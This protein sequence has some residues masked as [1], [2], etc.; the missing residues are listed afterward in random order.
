MAKALVYPSFYEG[1]GFQPLEAMA[2]GTPVVASHLT[3]LPEI[4]GDAGLLV[5]PY[6]SSSLASALDQVLEN[7]KLREI[8]IQKGFAQAGKFNWGR[9]AEEVLKAF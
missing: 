5:D 1:F 4:M 3:S 8:L 9:T 7:E 6:N 2:V